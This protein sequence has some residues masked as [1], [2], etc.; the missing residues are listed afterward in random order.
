MREKMRKR[1]NAQIDQLYG[2]EYSARKLRA[3]VDA[4]RWPPS[5]ITWSTLGTKKNTT[6]T[7]RQAS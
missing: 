5:S 3:R 4:S 6:H 7:N 2:V 1:R